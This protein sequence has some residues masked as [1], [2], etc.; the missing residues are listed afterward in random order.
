MISMDEEHILE[1]KKN[2]LSIKQL[3]HPS[4]I[5]YHALYF[6]LHKGIAYLVMEHFPYPNLAHIDFND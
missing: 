5:K 1:L 2:F 6:D 3:R 4:I